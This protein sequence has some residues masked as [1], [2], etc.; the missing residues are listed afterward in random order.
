MHMILLK[1]QMRAWYIKLRL[2]NLENRDNSFV[3]PCS[4]YL[5]SL[6]LPSTTMKDTE[7]ILKWFKVVINIFDMIIIFLHYLLFPLMLLL[8]INY[9]Q[10]IYFVI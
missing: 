4:I 6:K 8:Q 10:F 3:K 7:R 2:W 1:M 9:Q 5:N